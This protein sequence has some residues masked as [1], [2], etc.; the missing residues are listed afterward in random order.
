MGVEISGVPIIG[1][2]P[3]LPTGCEATALTMMLV[4]ACLS[5]TKQDVATRLPKQ[6]VPYTKDGTMYGGNP[7]LTF[8]GDPFTVNGY[9]VFHSAIAKL[10]DSYLPGNALDL[11]GG[12]FNNVTAAIDN[13][14]PVVV[15]IT[16]H[17]NEPRI[18]HQWVNIDE[19]EPR[20]INW[21]IP[22]HS[23]LVVGYSDTEIIVHDPNTAT[24]A[25]FDRGLF[26]LRWEQMGRQAVALKNPPKGG[27]Q[28]PK[29]LIS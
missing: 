13:G 15:I 7:D 1:Q 24:R 12:S 6:P 4:W 2:M 29:F 9:G 8:L 18:S 25:V 27:C 17:L 5:V 26:E 21:L 16:N 19:G 14:S 20:I 3:E 28:Q 10:L 11:S 23:V 22:E